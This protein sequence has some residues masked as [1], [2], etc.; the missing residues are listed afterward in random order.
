MS[1]LSVSQRFWDKVLFGDGCWEWTASKCSGGYGN[2]YYEN[3]YIGSHKASWSISNGPIPEGLCVC[4]R[5][6]NPAC[7]RPS[8]LFLGSISDNAKDRDSKGRGNRPQLPVRA[9]LSPDQVREISTAEG[10]QRDIASRFG[11]SQPCVSLIKRGLRWSE[12]V[13]A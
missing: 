6:D 4:H 12:H 1:K 3:G 9:K 11:V 8:H 10:S 7:V 13:A 5:C 2:F